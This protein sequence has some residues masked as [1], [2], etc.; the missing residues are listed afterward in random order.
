M[1]A[2]ACAVVEQESYLRGYD[3]ACVAVNRMLQ[4]ALYL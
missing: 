2:Y 1:A 3:G 4:L